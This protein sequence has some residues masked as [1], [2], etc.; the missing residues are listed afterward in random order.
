MAEPMTI[1][2]LSRF[3]IAVAA[4][5][6][7]SLGLALVVLLAGGGVLAALAVGSV[8]LF[9]FARVLWPGL[10]RWLD[11]DVWIATLMNAYRNAAAVGDSRIAGMCHR[12]IVMTTDARPDKD[13]DAIHIG[14]GHE[15]ADCGTCAAYSWVT[16]DSL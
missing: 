2:Q 12:K 15:P 14:I 3:G 16:A 8:G 5:A 1:E 9:L 11:D 7:I 10:R 6:A 4:T 13:W